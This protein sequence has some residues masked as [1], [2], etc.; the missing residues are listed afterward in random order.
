MDNT[1]RY[2][3]FVATL[4]CID[5]AIGQAPVAAESRNPAFAMRVSS[6]ERTVKPG[7]EITLDVE[8]SNVTEKE[9]GVASWSQPYTFEV[10]S[11]TGR[12]A[13][14]TQRGRL[15]LGRERVVENGKIRM[16][17]GG[18]TWL[19]RIAPSGTHRDQ[20][21][22]TELFDMRLPGEYIIRLRR[23]DTETSQLVTSNEV[24]VRVAN[25]PALPDEPRR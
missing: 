24:R 13:P 20:V 21:I 10:L 16:Q 3:A 5:C 9:I 7:A 1:I 6:K 15:I 8:I 19:L 12:P 4:V 23:A 25:D 11:Q 2:T 17:A 14:L 22:I 18:S